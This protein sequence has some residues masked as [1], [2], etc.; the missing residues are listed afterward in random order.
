MAGDLVIIVQARA[1]GTR[2]PGKV[3]MPLLGQSLLLWV[4][5]R[6]SHVQVPHELV[7]ACPDTPGNEAIAELCDNH[8]YP[9][10]LVP[11]P[12]NDVLA[13]YVWVADKYNARDILRCTADCPLIDPRVIDQLVAFHRWHTLPR[14]DHTGIGSYWPDGQDCEII[15]R[16]AHEIA[17]REGI[18]PS[19]RE[20]C[21]SFIWSHP[22]R[23]HLGN[24]PCSFDL[25]WQKYSVDIPED[26]DH[27]E[28]LLGFCIDRYGHIFGWREIWHAITCYK[29]IEASMRANVRNIAYVEQV[30]KERGLTEVP[31]WN[32][33]RYGKVGET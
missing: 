6:L 29:G 7:V 12:E 4:L 9:C 11:V 23:F 10:E 33:I 14:Y 5:D 25:S 13:R 15:S 18:P 31:E 17:H 30:A 19:E 2:F 28:R 3:L 16:N 22:E 26:L 27:V 32:T 20:H 24:F 8:G 21:S 1:G